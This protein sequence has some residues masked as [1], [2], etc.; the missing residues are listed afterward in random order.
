MHEQNENIS[1][2]IE[3][4][5]KDPTEILELR[6]VMSQLKNS[7]ESFNIRHEPV[8]ERISELT[9]KSYEITQL[10]EVLWFC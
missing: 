10:Q 2:E 7:I 5:K 1:K 9:E 3:T 4:T 6:N 8:E